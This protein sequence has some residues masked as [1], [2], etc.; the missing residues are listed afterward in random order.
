MGEGIGLGHFPF[1][2]R[3]LARLVPS[4]VTLLLGSVILLV[5]RVSGYLGFL[6]GWLIRDVVAARGEWLRC[7]VLGAFAVRGEGLW[8]VWVAL[9][10]FLFLW[11]LVLSLCRVQGHLVFPSH[12]F[13]LQPCGCFWACVVLPPPPSCSDSSGVASWLSCYPL[14][15]LSLAD[16]CEEEWAAL[17]L[18]P[19]FYYLLFPCYWVRVHVCHSVWWVSLCLPAWCHSLYPVTSPMSFSS[20]RGTFL[21]GRL[22][23]LTPHARHLSLRPTGS[24]GVLQAFS[25][26]LV[27]GYVLSCSPTGMAFIS[28]TSCGSDLI[29]LFLV[30]D[31]FF[32]LNICCLFPYTCKSYK[33]ILVVG[34]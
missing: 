13:A 8:R 17:L 12:G 30:L 23:Q 19:S 34:L 14:A 7:E 10:C 22:S 25:S 24:E 3:L 5:P 2:C 15:C 31:L 28:P 33:L 16:V 11:R 18:L 1:A 27:P 20:S 32:S 4:I 9:L 26:L 29:S 6:S 21:H